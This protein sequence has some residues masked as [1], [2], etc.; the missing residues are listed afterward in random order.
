M[1]SRATHCTALDCISRL[2]RPQFG[3]ITSWFEV[4]SAP[5]KTKPTN[6]DYLNGIPELLLLQLL[7]RLLLWR[8][9]RAP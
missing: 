5:M 6:P 2:T 8:W 7:L 9:A 1:Q 3:L 4:C